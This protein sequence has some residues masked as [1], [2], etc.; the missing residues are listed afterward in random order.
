M[1]K[2]SNWCL[3]GIPDHQGVYNVHGRLGAAKGPQAFR[4]VFR[5]LKGPAA[6]QNSL[7]DAGNLSVT[8][9]ISNNHRQAADFIYQHHKKTNLSVVVGGGHDH[10][11][12]Q[13]LALSKLGPVACINID[14]HLDV[15]KPSPIPSSGSP[16][17]LAIENGILNKKNFIEF[18]I[19]DHC[20]SQDL[21][22]YVESKDISVIPFKTLRNGNAVKK[23]KSA[24]EKLSIGNNQVVVSFDLDSV[25]CAFAPGVSAPQS[26]GFTPSEIIEMMEISGQNKKVSSLG[27]FELN[28]LHDI[29]KSTARLAA[30]AA[31]HFIEE[32]LGV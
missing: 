19:Q 21:W 20:N 9:D 24:L 7:I 28:P 25:A 30:T 22:D 14:A 15:R 2:R 32:A 17:Y 4:D 23:F 13:L 27:I 18:G 5:F 3:L 29:E 16:F 26:E 6:V 1:S 8:R 10:G 12:S 31:Y 11:Y